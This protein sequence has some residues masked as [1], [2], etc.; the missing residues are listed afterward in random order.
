M[1]DKEAFLP[2]SSFYTAFWNSLGSDDDAALQDVTKHKEAVNT[3][4]HA[5]L[6]LQYKSLEQEIE[7]IAMQ[8]GVHAGFRAAA[9]LRRGLSSK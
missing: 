4:L 5:A 1:V 9:E 6:T 2:K 8:A 3:A 7:R